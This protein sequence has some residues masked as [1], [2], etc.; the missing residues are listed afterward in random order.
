MST[1]DELAIGIDVSGTRIAVAAF[2]HPHYVNFAITQRLTA[3]KQYD[4]I[5]HALREMAAEVGEPNIVG[6]EMPFLGFPKS[7]FIHGQ[8]VART[9]DACRAVWPHA[10]QRFMQPSEWRKIAGVGGKASK[11]RVAEF[12]R[13]EFMFTPKNQDEAD[14]ACIAIATWV[15][16]FGD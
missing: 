16:A 6:I 3:G 10:P 7:A 4:L 1:R 11:E 14:A 2:S 12:V 8:C 9:E 5:K 15:E 13:D